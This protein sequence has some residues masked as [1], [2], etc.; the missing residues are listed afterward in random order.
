MHEESGNKSK[1]K[2]VSLHDSI[3]TCRSNLLSLGGAIYRFAK[4][5]YTRCEADM[6]HFVKILAFHIN[7]E[8]L[9]STQLF[10]KRKGLFY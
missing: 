1:T 10:I 6:Y 8:N 4:L 2:N 7:G 9:N 3:Y 5:C